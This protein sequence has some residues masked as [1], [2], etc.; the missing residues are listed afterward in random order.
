M[1]A[2]TELRFRKKP[3]EIEAFQMTK[4]RRMDNSGWPNW[5]NQ[6]WNGARNEA[7]TLQR[8]DMDA[9][10]PDYLQIVTLEGL[11]LVSWGDWIIRGVKGELYPCKPDIF[12]ATY[13]SAALPASE[14][15]SEASMTSEYK[16]LVAERRAGELFSYRGPHYGPIRIPASEFR[17]KAAA[18]IET[19]SAQSVQPQAGEPVAHCC[20]AISPCS[21]QRHHGMD[22]VCP[23]CTA[24]APASPQPAS[25]AQVTENG[26]EEAAKIITKWLGYSWGGLYDGRV[27]D[28]GFPIFTHGQ[29]GWGFQG[30]KGDMIDLARTALT[31]AIGAGGQAVAVKPLEWENVRVNY[32]PE[33]YEAKS[34]VG[35]YQVFTDEDS[36]A[37]A[38]LAEWALDSQHFGMTSATSLGRYPGFEAAKAAAQA[39]YGR[40]I[41]SALSQPHPADE[42]VVEA[43]APHWADVL[44]S[45]ADATHVQD[46]KGTVDLLR[47]TAD[48]IEAALRTMEGRN[49]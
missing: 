35:L 3:V 24:A 13:E 40:R 44:R 25:P 28:K 26:I 8:V 4:E 37:G 34:P 42:R 41:L 17:Q 6:A 2:P 12:E 1:T 36:A 10:L 11:H 14:A 33:T 43:L 30:H 32:G 45:R 38:V 18:A 16:A 19:L 5:L 48:K 7:G 20:S 39:D 49:G 31:A 9:Q 27:T 15:G 46:S 47:N 23:T 29:F 21:W 22:A